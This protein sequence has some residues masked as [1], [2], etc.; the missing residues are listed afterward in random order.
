MLRPRPRPPL[1]PYTTLFRSTAAAAP[2]GTPRSLHPGAPADPRGHCDR[3]PYLSFL[4][5]EFTL[6]RRARLLLS[7]F[8]A[9]GVRR[10]LF[11]LAPRRFLLV[12]A[13]RFD[14]SGSRRGVQLL[15]HANQAKRC[16]VDRLVL[17]DVAQ[18]DVFSLLASGAERVLLTRDRTR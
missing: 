13:H 3:W 14:F 15:R 9:S 18:R 16:R 11:S 1:F 7:G 4:R 6:V 8:P 2:P 10:R 5:E 17:S 12:E